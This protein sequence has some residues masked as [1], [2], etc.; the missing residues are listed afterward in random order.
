MPMVRELHR[1]RSRLKQNGLPH[2]FLH[3]QH[4]ISYGRYLLYVLRQRWPA[5]QTMIFV[6]DMRLS[7]R[8]IDLNI[9]VHR[10]SSHEPLMTFARARE[11]DD[12]DWPV[13]S[14]LGEIKQRFA[15][16][17]WCFCAEQDR[18][19]VSVI[20]VSRGPCYLS[21]VDYM[22]KIPD[23]AVGLYDVYTL[24]AYR[25]RHLY[26]VVFQAAI[27]AC[28]AEGYK[29]A[30]M[31]IMPDNIVSFSTHLKLGM[32]HIFCGIKLRQRWG[33]RRHRIHKLDLDAGK[34]LKERG[35]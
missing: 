35:F 17:D 2:Y 19:F 23:K 16:G 11:Q 7:N 3:P 12:K 6:L 33:F 4:F 1:I 28:I 34:M 25:G 21:P 30:W 15:A 24:A 27:N 10:I 20:F 22:L 14:Y 13:G 26:S 8:S 32:R 18:R 5:A 9:P 29:S 31:W